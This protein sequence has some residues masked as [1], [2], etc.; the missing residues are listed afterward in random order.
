MRL[1]PFGEAEN[2]E[3]ATEARAT[4]ALIN[5]GV[6]LKSLPPMAEAIGAVE[7][8]AGLWARAFASAT[9]DPSNMVTGA[10]TPAVLAAMGRGLAVHGGGVWVIGVTDRVTLTQ[11]SAWDIGGGARP[12]EWTYT[13]ELPLPSGQCPKAHS[14]SGRRDSLEIC[15][16]AG[17]SACRRVSAR[18]GKRNAGAGGLARKTSS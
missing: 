13:V 12:E 9:V 7:A 3:S 17:S 2:R 15:H 16:K 11:A 1:W 14:T 18:H 4:E 6:R 10:L 5:G 8:A